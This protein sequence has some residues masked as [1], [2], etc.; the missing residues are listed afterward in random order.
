MDS[1]EWQTESCR[2]VTWD[3]ESGRS[4]P[5]FH[6]HDW[7]RSLEL[8]LEGGR[9]RREELKRRKE[10]VRDRET[11]G[12]REGGRGYEGGAVST[13]FHDDLCIPYICIYLLF[14]SCLVHH[15]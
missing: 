3:L 14:V 6:R 2:L 8:Q 5:D 9:G 15:S 1:L 12:G 11:V 10:R 7:R 4:C 13:D